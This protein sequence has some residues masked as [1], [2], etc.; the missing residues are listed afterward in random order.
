MKVLVP[1]QYVQ[2]EA[3]HLYLIDSNLYSSINIV[4][5]EI[6]HV[7]CT[8]DTRISC[9]IQNYYS[10]FQYY[11]EVTY[12]YSI[13]IINMELPSSYELF[14]IPGLQFRHHEC[15]ETPNQL[16]VRMPVCQYVLCSPACC[17]GKYRLATTTQIHRKG[18]N[19]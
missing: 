7:H 6:Q 4:S 1:V 19:G 14:H 2:I 15:H 12:R 16:P 5:S 13:K 8:C 9:N 10:N 3:I 11:R 18:K 17:H